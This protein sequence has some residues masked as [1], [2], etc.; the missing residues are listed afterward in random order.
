MQHETVTIVVRILKVV[1][2]VIMLFFLYQTIANFAVTIGSWKGGVSQYGQA[3]PAVKGFG[4]R[5]ETLV[6]PLFLFVQ[7]VLIS[8]LTWGFAELFAM[9]RECVTAN[10]RLTAAPSEG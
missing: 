3:L 4:A 9:A 10:R 6:S 7:G 2:A 8:A 1:A 5:F